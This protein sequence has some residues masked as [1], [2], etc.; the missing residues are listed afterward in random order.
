MSAPDTRRVAAASGVLPAAFT[1]GA[2]TRTLGR[3]TYDDGR[4]VKAAFLAR[5]PAF[6]RH[7]ARA[8]RL[9][10][11]AG[12]L[13]VRVT[14]EVRDRREQPSPGEARTPVP[15]SPAWGGGEVP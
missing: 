12:D 4:A 14:T 7:A 9:P 3:T 10:A 6:H 8:A 15:D 2:G 5:R 1:G 13:A 11:G